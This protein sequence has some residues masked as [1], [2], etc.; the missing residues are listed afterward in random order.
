MSTCSFIKGS[1][2]PVTLLGATCVLVDKREPL[3]LRT[4]FE[5]ISWENGQADAGGGTGLQIRWKSRKRK[6]C[7]SAREEKK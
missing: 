6:L 7:P 5:M 4:Q 3:A 1:Y 2:S